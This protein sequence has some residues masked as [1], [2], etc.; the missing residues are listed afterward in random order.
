M[1]KQ[2]HSIDEVRS[3][4]NMMYML[5]RLVTPF[6]IR[7]LQLEGV[8]SVFQGQDTLCLLPTAA[9]KSLIFQ[10][11]PSLFTECCSPAPSP[12]VIVVSPLVALMQ[13]QVESANSMLG[14]KLNAI[15]MKPGLSD[16]ELIGHNLLIGSPEIWLEKRCRNFLASKH[17][18]KNAVCLV[19]DEV[20]KVTW[21]L[22]ICLLFIIQF[23]QF[24]C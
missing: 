15:I 5:N 2:Y 24:L 8:F 11:L 19:V 3:I 17:V 10:I 18:R 16:D 13:D 12:L 1:A 7:E 20:H 9:G 23:S 21:Y 4:C 22:F 14:L 6:V